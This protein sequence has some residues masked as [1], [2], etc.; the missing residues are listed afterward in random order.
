MLLC[1]RA[2]DRALEGGAQKDGVNRVLV[3]EK[4][5]K[6]RKKKITGEHA[7]GGTPIERSQDDAR[8][9]KREIK[10][11]GIRNGAH[12]LESESRMNKIK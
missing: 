8:V 4:W 7:G 11:M 1:Y 2:L 10:R 12:F 5:K 6:G 3:A 9:I